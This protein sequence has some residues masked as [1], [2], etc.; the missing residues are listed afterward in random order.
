M[1]IEGA[2]AMITPW[3]GWGRDFPCAERTRNGC[4]T[5]GESSGRLELRR[6]VLSVSSLFWVNSESLIVLIGTK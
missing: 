5:L 3:G 2:E 1:S 6:A 4:R